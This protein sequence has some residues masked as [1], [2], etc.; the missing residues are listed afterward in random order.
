MEVKKFLE[1]RTKG[2]GRNRPVVR[3][4]AGF[5]NVVILLFTFSSEAAAQEALRPSAVRLEDSLRVS[6][7]G[8]DRSLNTFTWNGTLFLD[9]EFNGIEFKLRQILRSRLIRTDPLSIQDEYGDS[10]TIAL[11]SLALGRDLFNKCHRWSRTIAR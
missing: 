9:R 10:L 1:R 6:S 3:C 8:F 11:R 2:P 7:F 5:F 4:V